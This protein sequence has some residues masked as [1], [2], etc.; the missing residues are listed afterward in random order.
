L[1]SRQERNRLKE[2]QAS[3]DPFALKEEL[4]RRLG[5]I[6]RSKTK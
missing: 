5:K 4:E 2:E 3:L 1:L 6:L